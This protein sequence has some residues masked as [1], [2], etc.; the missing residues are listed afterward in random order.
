MGIAGFSTWFQKQHPGAYLPLSNL[1]PFDHVYI[2]MASILHTV[3]RRGVAR[4]IQ[5][6]KDVAEEAACTNVW[7]TRLLM[8][9]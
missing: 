3:L 7:T 6:R 8:N 9:L 1:P 2:D 5:R 4:G